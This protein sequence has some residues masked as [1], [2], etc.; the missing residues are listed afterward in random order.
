MDIYEV[1]N[2][3]AAAKA[4][5]NR[6]K[7]LSWKWPKATPDSLNWADPSCVGIQFKHSVGPNISGE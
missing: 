3:Q 5:V 6:E 1:V 7:R 4:Q 2:Q